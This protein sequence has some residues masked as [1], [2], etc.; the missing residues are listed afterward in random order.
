M[1]VVFGA[2]GRCGQAVVRAALRAGLAV[3]PVV[4]DD[5]EARALDRVIDVNDVRYADPAHVGSIDLALAGGTALITALDARC[6][7]HGA[8]R[9]DD[10]A[11]RRVM[12]RAHALGMAPLVHLCV[13]GAYRWSPHPLNRRSFRS[14]RQIRLATS[15]PWTAI[16]ISCFHDELIDGHLRPPD[17]RAP[18]PF[19]D[20]ARL[21]PI[22]RDEL[23]ERLVARL[24]TLPRNRTLYVGGPE[25]WT[26]EALRALVP[27]S[28]RLARRTA[29]GA[30][31]PGDLSV[32]ADTSR[33]S[34][35]ER[36][37]I[38]LQQAILSASAAPP[39]RQGPWSMTGPVAPHPADPGGPI[40]ALP[41]LSA[42]LRKA[43][44]AA[45]QRDLEALGHPPGGLR[46]DWSAATPNPRHKPI[47]VYDG[48]LQATLEVRALG[49]DGAPLHT[50]ELCAHWDAL[51]DVLLVWFSR[52]D[53]RLPAH[54]WASLD[55]GVQRRLRGGP[56]APSGE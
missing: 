53:G 5:R 21:S 15:L 48:Q 10:G 47:H 9:L 11:G 32:S 38:G 29:W 14:D 22:C 7:G 39:A 4:R 56:L 37:V 17:G 12:E 28:P 46:L 31:P 30:L 52:P 44:H 13:V 20:S 25:V 27:P 41:G 40:A 42:P 55:L 54:L 6:W 49:P 35:G 3:R 45:L 19:P 1:L 16:R 23:A 34:L 43:V 24:P 33:V 8:A 26:A 36:P 18:H 50:G 2:G 51:G